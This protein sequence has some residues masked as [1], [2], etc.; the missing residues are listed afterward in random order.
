VRASATAD[1]VHLS[2]LLHLGSE[3]GGE[4]KGDE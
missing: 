4:T 3:R 2:H 1:P